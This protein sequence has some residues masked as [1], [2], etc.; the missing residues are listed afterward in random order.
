MENLKNEVVYVDEVTGEAVVFDKADGRTFT[1]V[2]LKRERV[3]SQ[4]LKKMLW[5]YYV[6]GEIKGKKVKA[7]FAPQ[8]KDDVMTFTNLDIIFEGDTA[9][10]YC[11]KSSYKTKEGQVRTTT[12]YKVIT[13]DEFDEEF[14][15]TVIPQKDSDKAIFD[16]LCR[17][18]KKLA[19]Q[20]AEK[21]ALTA[22]GGDVTPETPPAE[23]P[24]K[25]NKS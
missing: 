25:K 4:K 2:Y 13:T 18:A 3:P 20:E 21:A 16:Y 10:I 15:A 9:P 23:T 8:S 22:D 14:S 5:I 7:N 19:E 12:V 6:E 17:R 1:G 24:G 11:E